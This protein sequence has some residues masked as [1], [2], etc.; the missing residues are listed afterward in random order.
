MEVGH[1]GELQFIIGCELGSAPQDFFG[2]TLLGESRSQRLK[3][4][5]P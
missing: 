3:P 4:P 5:P 2:Q 1:D